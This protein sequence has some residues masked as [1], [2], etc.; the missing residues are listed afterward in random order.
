VE[1]LTSYSLRQEVRDTLKRHQFLKDSQ[2][3][4]E[5][6]I[7]R[8][9]RQIRVYRKKRPKTYWCPITNHYVPYRVRPRGRSR[10]ELRIRML[11][12]HTV[13]RA[14]RKAFMADPVINNR[15]NDPRPFT[16][17]AQDIFVIEPME[18]LEDNLEHY[19]SYVR[20]LLKIY[21]RR[22]S[23]ISTHI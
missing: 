7:V 11:L 14:W 6:M 20:R 17:F 8:A 9:I 10:D 21:L 19:Q 15:G 2:K 16:L 5:S 23:V 3:V 12:M 4:C 22:N 13:F 18:N 1:A